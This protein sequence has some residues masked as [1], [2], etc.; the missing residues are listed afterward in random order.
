[1]NMFSLE[2]M[3]ADRIGGEKFGKDTT[4]YKFE[5]IKRA[6]RAA[7]E[8]NPGKEL[9]DMGVGEPD[10]KAFDKIIKTLISEADKHENRG[11]ADNGI[12]VFQK[13]ASV[14]MKDVFGVDGIDDETEVVHS[15]GSKP[16]L[17]MLPLT[18]INPG[19][20]ALMTVPGYPVFGTHTKYLGGEVFTLPLLKENNFLPD[21]DSI[22]SDILKRAK[23]MVL[24][25]PNNPTGRS[26]DKKF[27]EKVVA[28]AKENGIVVVHDAAYAALTY[29]REP[30]SF[31]SVPGAKDVGI[32]LH[33]LS[34]SFNM[35]GWRI[36]FVTG[37]PGLVS[38]YATVKDNVDSGQ[39][40]AIQQAAAVALADPGITKEIS[41]KYERRLK[42]ITGILNK[43]GFQASMPHGTFFLYVPAPKGTEDGIKFANA[44]E[45][46]Q[47]LIKE[48][49]ISTVPFDDAGAFVRFSA[50][51]VAKDEADEA[52]VLKE[53][54]DRL[55]SVKPVF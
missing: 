50:T 2:T 22:P 7:L 46:S 51:F 11:Y 32:E 44:E 13:A 55:K 36:G 28:F 25:Y 14:Y 21:L 24:N 1:M 12:E 54:E 9:L 47:F 29:D 43:L 15:I 41:G 53:L 26:A 5:K 42:A 33:S 18:L 35:T 23:V 19:D 38:A 8:A 34:K 20:V 39:F 3:Y 4:I 17:A 27:F 45:F 40:K 16:A 49:L 10:A 48:K 30:I 37:N 6:K 52:R 31:L